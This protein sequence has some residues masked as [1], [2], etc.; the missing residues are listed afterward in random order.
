MVRAALA[1]LTIGTLAGAATLAPS[2]FGL[3]HEQWVWLTAPLN[4]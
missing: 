3:T 2:I 4:R 1:G